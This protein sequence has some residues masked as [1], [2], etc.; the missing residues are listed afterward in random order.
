MAARLIQTA[1]GL[2]HL[3]G[4]QMERRHPVD[5]FA[6]FQTLRIEAGNP[7]L[8][9]QDHPVFP[10]ALTRFEAGVQKQHGTT[11]SRR[12]ALSGPLGWIGFVQTGA[13]EGTRTPTRFR[14]GT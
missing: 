6:K 10:L 4:G 8:A 11:L 9:A 13:P 3:P 12:Q 14:N 7:A 2:Q 1:S 5:H